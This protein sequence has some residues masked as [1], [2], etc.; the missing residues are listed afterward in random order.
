MQ[1]LLKI[2][3]KFHACYSGGGGGGGGGTLA[4]SNTGKHVNS[5]GF[6]VR[7]HDI[8]CVSL[9]GNQ[10]FSMFLSQETRYFLR[11]F[12]RKLDI[13]YVSQPG[14]QIF[15]TFLCQETRYFLCFSVGKLVVSTKFPAWKYAVPRS[16]QV[17]G[18]SYISPCWKL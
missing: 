9:S 3:N 16:I 15:S 13:F 18:N 17:I 1:L 7:N 12:V 2:T 4:V 5:S 14:N 6:T 10:I 8:F 11:F